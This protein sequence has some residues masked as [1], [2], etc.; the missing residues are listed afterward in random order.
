[1]GFN[2]KY[3]IET[4][5]VLLKTKTTGTHPGPTGQSLPEQDLGMFI[6]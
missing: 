4:H 5:V 2:Q 3:A 1:M 6:V